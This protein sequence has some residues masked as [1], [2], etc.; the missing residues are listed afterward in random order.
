MSQLRLKVVISGP[1]NA[2][3]TCLVKRLCENKFVA[4]W[5]STIGVDYGVT[6]ALIRSGTATPA[7]TLAGAP[8]AATEGVHARVNIFDLGG[9]DAYAEIRT[10]FYN[11][12]HVVSLPVVIPMRASYRIGQTITPGV[13]LPT[14]P[15]QLL[16]VFDMSE[17][18]SFDSLPRW[19]D[20]AKA[21]GLGT[22]VPI[23]ACGSKSDLVKAVT[24]E[25]ARTWAAQHGMM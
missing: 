21:S 1:S 4:R 11:D 7:G 2:G 12:C 10:E 24:T 3:K 6:P 16:L 22:N 23:V 25:E 18:P 13:R 14:L 15:T 17:R 20:E 5:I 9:H 8:T 19:L